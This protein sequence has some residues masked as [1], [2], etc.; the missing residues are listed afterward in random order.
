M[1]VRA[2]GALE[3]S[4]G[5]L[6]TFTLPKE[7]FKHADPKASVVLEARQANGKPLPDWLKFN[8]GTGRFT[9]KA[10]SGLKQ[11]EVTVFAR[12][13][14]GQEASTKVILDFNGKSEVKGR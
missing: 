13:T 6:F 11:L 14:S 9:G 7:T 10:P 4:P 8:P 12:D 3:V 1:S 5:A 2:F